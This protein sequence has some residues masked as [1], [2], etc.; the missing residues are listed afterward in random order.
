MA[1][2][3]LLVD[4]DDVRRQQL[5]TVL[6]FMGIPW[7]EVVES[8][9]DV[10]I[11]TAGPLQG[12]LAGELRERALS[13]LLAAHPRLPFLS[14][15]PA[16]HGCSN[17][18]GVAE[19]PFTYESLTRH[20][21][22]CQAF[23]SLHPRHQTHDKGQ[24]LLRLL[25]G[26]GRGI[27]EV[28]RLIGQV[29]ETDANVLILGESGTGKEVVAR[30][31]HELSARSAGPFVP[32]NCGAI[33]AELLESE[34]FGH[35]KGAFT[36]AIA[37]RRGRFELAQGGTLFLDEIG[38]M[39]LPMQVKLLRVLQERQ[40]D[41]VG[42]GKAVQAD[43]R[44][45]AA[46]HRDLEAMIRTQ[47]FREDLYYRLNVFPIETPPLRDRA[48]DIPLLLQ[49]LLNRHA[50]QHKGIIR[51]TQRAMESL[52]QYA[53]PGNV[54]ELSNLIERLL[55]LY[56]NQIV[57][58]ADLPGRYR[59]LPCEPRDERLTEMDERDA[60][61]AVFQSP[62]E[63]DPGIAMPLPMQLPQEGVNLKEMLADL[64]VELI[65]QALESQDGVVARAADLLSMRRTTL[66]EKMKKYGMS[67]DN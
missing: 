34:L 48:D 46:T 55:I 12:I 61:A 9:L 31:I 62:P 33:P 23:I 10:A 47:A 65:R 28:R 39:P 26:K 38:D 15:M 11:E 13:E 24:T 41:R 21:H 18:I 36:G 6:S 49:E 30:A 25:V 44:V 58:V 29:A 17:F 22:F 60:L 32:I 51:L 8:D 5:G 2:G 67:K 50:E 42:G 27:Q 40:F 37:A 19:A 45:I 64:E 7:Q 56:P 4:A 54:R 63:L 59:L 52:M 1:M 16:S 3:V 66:V 14:L 57:D 20:L 35:E 53:W 43:V